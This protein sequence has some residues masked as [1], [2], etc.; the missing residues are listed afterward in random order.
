MNTTNGNMDMREMAY[1]LGAMRKIIGINLS[2]MEM[3][4][5]IKLKG[6]IRNILPK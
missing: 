6:S 4:Y 1:S 5:K 3:D 2:K